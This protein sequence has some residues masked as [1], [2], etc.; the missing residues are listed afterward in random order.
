MWKITPRLHTGIGV[1]NT[2]HSHPR[3]VAAAKEQLDNIVHS[4]VNVGFHD[5]ML[6]LTESLLPSYQKG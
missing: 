5:K 6:E 3:I 4:Q 1:L 2:G